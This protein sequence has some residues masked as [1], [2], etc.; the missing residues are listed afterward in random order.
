LWAE[1]KLEEM[2][3]EQK[4]FTRTLERIFI[5]ER[6]YKRIEEMKTPET[7]KKAVYDGFVPFRR[8]LA[9]DL[10]D[11]D[12]EHL[13]KIP[14][15]RISL[16]DIN[17]M[18]DEIKEL[19]ARLNEVRF[20]KAHLTDYAIAFI[21]GILKKYAAEYPRRTQIVSFTKVD[22]R[23]AAQRNLKLRYDKTTGYLG[24]EVDGTLLFEVSTFDRVLCIRKNGIYSVF[25]VPEKMFVDKG[26]W[27]CGLADK[28]QLAKTVFSVLFRDE[29]TGFPYVKRCNVEGWI[30]S[31]G[32]S[33]IPENSTL[34]AFTTEQD[35]RIDLEYK[36][37]PRLKVLQETLALKDYLIKGA[38][39]GGVRLA[40]KEIRTAKFG[41]PT[42]PTQKIDIVA[43][44]SKP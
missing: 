13:L 25:D 34:L 14:I 16:Y 26:M 27:W 29:E 8:E 6:I 11:E 38:K 32:Y 4:I 15:R 9:R 3:L 21:D 42:E 2:Q 7:V 17:R 1:L 44:Q 24:Y 36:P 12:V 22:I 28:E 23:E 5:V 10:T 33:L 19:N 20:H 18:Q 30:L 43:E 37:K 31:K 40:N 41:K 39:S 35:A